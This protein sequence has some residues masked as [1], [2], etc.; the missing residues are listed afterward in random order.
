MAATEVIHFPF[1]VQ[2][3]LS[4]TSPAFGDLKSY[5]TSPG[6]LSPVKAYGP[7]TNGAFP[8]LAIRGGGA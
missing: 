5:S 6:L 7:K 4:C 2:L 3:N 8:A 1:K